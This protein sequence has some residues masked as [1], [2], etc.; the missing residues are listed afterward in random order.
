MSEQKAVRFAPETMRAVEA[1]VDEMN[2]A[3]PPGSRK[4]TPSDALR[5][6]VHEALAARA[7]RA[8]REAKK[9]AK[10]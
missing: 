5:V 10:K 4:A 2:A 7:A 3:L 1:L 8:A 9:A 6:L